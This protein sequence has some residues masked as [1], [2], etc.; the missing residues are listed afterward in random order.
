M[1]AT[2]VVAVIRLK[3]IL[4]ETTGL[5]KNPVVALSFIW[6]IFNV[7]VYIT[8][9][10]TLDPKSTDFEGFD[11]FEGYMLAA[12]FFTF[13]PH[14]LCMERGKH[15]FFGIKHLND[16]VILVPTFLLHYILSAVIL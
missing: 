13:V 4:L 1:A 11:S 6:Y 3:A 9:G 15:N 10:I 12:V 2:A 5:N 16:A 8:H 14:L 7:V